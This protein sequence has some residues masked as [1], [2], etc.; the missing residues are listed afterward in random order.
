[1][2]S[3]YTKTSG[4]IEKGISLIGKWF[5]IDE[6]DALAADNFNQTTIAVRENTIEFQGYRQDTEFRNIVDKLQPLNNLRIALNDFYY[7]INVIN[8]DFI[9][10][11]VRIRFTQDLMNVQ[12]K[13]R[14]SNINEDVLDIY[15]E[16][17]PQLNED[18]LTRKTVAFYAQDERSIIN[19]EVY[20]NGVKVDD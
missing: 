2:T 17:M 12:V 1:M 16:P 8:G 13:V 14:N 10:T 9:I 6:L 4:R 19:H 3:V 5:T 15:R 7:P 20:V 11:D 18:D